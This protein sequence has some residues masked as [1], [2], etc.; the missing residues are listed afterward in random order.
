M[1]K[2]PGALHRQLKLSDCIACLD[3]K[4]KLRDGLL[5]ALP[6][7]QCPSELGAETDSTGKTCYR[8][9][10]GRDSA[11][12][13]DV[14]GGNTVSDPVGIVRMHRHSRSQSCTGGAAAW[15][16]TVRPQ[17]RTK[18]L[19]NAVRT[20]RVFHGRQPCRAGT[21]SRDDRGIM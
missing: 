5:N 18:A 3:R 10:T 15:V 19:T 2:E 14:L 20:T 1:S 4:P 7:Q 17:T 16:G 9:L 13:V 11:L 12:D 8:C 21:A 6:S